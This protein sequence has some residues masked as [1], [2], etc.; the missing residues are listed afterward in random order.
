MSSYDINHLVSWEGIAEGVE[1]TNYFI[2]T[3]NNNF[4]LTIYE[5]RVRKKDLPF[6]INLLSHLAKNNFPCPKPI[7]NKKGL[8]SSI[9]KEKPAALFSFLPGES[10]NN[11]SSNNCYK[12][13]HFLSV[14]H[15]SSKNF[16]MQRDNK[17]S[18]LGWN[19]LINQFDNKINSIHENLFNIINDELIF[20]S[21][22]WPKNLP[23]GIIHADLFPD[24][25][26]FQNDEIS[27]VIDFYFA[28]NDFF[29]YDIA[30]TLNAWCFDEKNALDKNKSSSL[31][32]GYQKLRKL[33][34]NEKELFPILL[35]G[36]ALRF[37]LTRIYDLINKVDGAIVKTKNP[38][39][40]LN[41]L[42][43]HKNIS[44]FD[45]YVL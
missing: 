44:S 27:G 22:N 21:D 40:Y 4:I 25:V 14:V 28:C 42:I 19:D 2:N 23:S 16:K 13:G 1:N 34:K 39:E 6:F 32:N 36:A 20:L 12:A 24:N 10:I 18:L 37:L 35:R 26:F 29:A 7:S 43:Y 9:L 3:K 31:I 5:K 45:H 8:A 30:I 15:E 17:L 38:I 41:K 11:P 33:E